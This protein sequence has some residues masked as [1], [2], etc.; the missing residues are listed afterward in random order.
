MGS[1][2]GLQGRLERTRKAPGPIINMVQR[3][4]FDAALV[5]AA[6]TAGAVVCETAVVTRLTQ[7]QDVVC[8][9][10]RDH[11]TIRARAVVGADGSA[12]QN[13]ALHKAVMN[14]LATNGGKVPDSLRH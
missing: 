6:I 13:L 10:T 1:R 5:K 9:S 11:G 14:A 7:E 2:E 12:E 8:L 3:D 4:E